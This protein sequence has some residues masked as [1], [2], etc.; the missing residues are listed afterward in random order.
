MIHADLHEGNNHGTDDG[1]ITCFD[2]D[3]SGDGWRAY[4]RAVFLAGNL[5]AV[6][7]ACLEG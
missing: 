4:N 1:Q 3:H 6:R 7:A 5:D 2:F